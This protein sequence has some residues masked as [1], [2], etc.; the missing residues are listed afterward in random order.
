M[1]W[2]GGFWLNEGGGGGV[3]GGGGGIGDLFRLAPLPAASVEDREVHSSSTAR[4]G[5]M[6][7]EKR[8][9]ARAHVGTR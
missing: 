3:D 9:C 1:G 6:L 2:G 4:R 5:G 7:G 8:G